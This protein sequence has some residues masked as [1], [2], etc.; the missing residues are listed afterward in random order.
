[1]KKIRF[2]ERMP[3]ETTTLVYEII[4]TDCDEA[5]QLYCMVNGRKKALQTVKT[6]ERTYT[7]QGTLH[8]HKKG[9][10]CL[11]FG[12]ETMDGSFLFFGNAMTKG[13]KQPQC[14]TLGEAMRKIRDTWK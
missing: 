4:I 6:G 14:A 3:E 11:R 13:E 1:M 2:G 5:A 9:W 10:D 8:L 12:A 7:V